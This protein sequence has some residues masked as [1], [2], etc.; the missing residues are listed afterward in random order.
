[1][2]EREQEQVVGQEENEN[3]RRK[4]KMK[5]EGR[6]DRAIGK[7]TDKTHIATENKSCNTSG[8]QPDSR[9]VAEW[10]ITDKDYVGK[11]HQKAALP[12]AGSQLVGGGVL[13]VGDVPFRPSPTGR[14]GGCNY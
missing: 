1:M 5:A 4:T 9:G 8:Q 3:E 14:S 7:L 11:F 10:Q 13:L 6:V 12:D 2:E